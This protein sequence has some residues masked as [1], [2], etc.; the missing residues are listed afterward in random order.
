[1]ANFFSNLFHNRKRES[2]KPSEYMKDHAEMDQHQE[3]HEKGKGAANK[4]EKS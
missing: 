1:M 3:F 2:L 4:G